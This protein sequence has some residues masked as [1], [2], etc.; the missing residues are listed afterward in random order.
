MFLNCANL[1]IEEQLNDENY[2]IIY[3]REFINLEPSVL[4]EIVV[5]S[6]YLK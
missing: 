5:S 1:K 4:T 3:F 6:E 2:E